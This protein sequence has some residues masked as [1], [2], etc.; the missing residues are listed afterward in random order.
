MLAAITN[1]KSTRI[2]KRKGDDAD[3]VQAIDPTAEKA[4]KSCMNNSRMATEWCAKVAA[5]DISKGQ[6]K[7]LDERTPA[8]QHELLK[9]GTSALA[10]GTSVLN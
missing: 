7:F 3:T 5:G 10:E 8:R 2:K 6:M 9:A 4:V 1:A